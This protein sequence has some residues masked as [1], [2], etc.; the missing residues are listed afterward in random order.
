MHKN[1]VK[2]LKSLKV[3]Y[4][5]TVSS[6]DTMNGCNEWNKWAGPIT[7]PHPPPF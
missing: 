4:P 7:L 6:M 2:V 1:M 5:L 3:V